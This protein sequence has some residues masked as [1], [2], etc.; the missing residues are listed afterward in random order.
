MR[1]NSGHKALEILEKKSTET[2]SS[3]AKSQLD[4]DYLLKDIDGMMINNG[5]NIS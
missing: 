2:K 4:M 1:G 3:S 5:Y